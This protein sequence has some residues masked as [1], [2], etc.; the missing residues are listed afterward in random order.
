MDHEA[1]MFNSKFLHKNRWLFIFVVIPTIIAAIYYTFIA[2]DRYSS[3]SRFVIK[4][5]SERPGQISTLAS[6]IQTT[7]LSAGQEQTN[8]IIGYLRS[9]GALSDMSSAIDVKSAFGISKA[10]PLSG[11]PQPFHTANFENLY[12]YYMNMVK[13]NVD[14]NTGLAVLT[15][16][17]FT[18]NG[19][20]EVNTELLRL[21]EVLVNRLNEK[22][23]SNSINEDEGQ[24]RIAED[25]VRKAGIALAKYRNKSNLLDPTVQASGVFQV[26]TKLES[27]RASLQAQLEIMRQVTPENPA[28]VTL[29]KQISALSAQILSQTGDAV[30]SN[31]A[32]SSKL[33][34]YQSLVLEQ[35]FASQT[36]TAANTQLAQARAEAVQQQYYLERVSPPNLPDEANQ[37][38]RFM[39]VLTIAVILLCLYLIGWMLV[40]GILEHA[41]ED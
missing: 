38:R 30:G 34:E 18:P 39:K 40:V 17:A 22:A 19:A 10:D 11:F 7:G 4:N 35:Q 25:R 32:I 14:T 16:Q 6:L 28:I 37:P 31:G 24:V 2:S 1:S 27:E 8:E 36:L 3:E 12:D 23:R 29:Q 41:P 9:R 26:A 13:V 21:S 33:A 15:T 5:V 20:R